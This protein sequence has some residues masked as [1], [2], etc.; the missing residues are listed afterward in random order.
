MQ[1]RHIF[2]KNTYTYKGWF[3]SKYSVFFPPYTN[4]LLYINVRF[5]K[6]KN[7]SFTRGQAVNIIAIYVHYMEFSDF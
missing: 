5:N 2:K 6:K 1:I 4:K 3:I 7:L